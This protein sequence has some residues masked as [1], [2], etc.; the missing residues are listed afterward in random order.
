MC[1]LRSHPRTGTECPSMTD[2][3]NT[4][5][6][7]YSPFRHLGEGGP[8]HINQSIEDFQEPTTAQA[9]GTNKRDKRELIPADFVEGVDASGPPVQRSG[10]EAVSLTRWDLGLP[11]LESKR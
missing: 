9:R 1:R 6:E 5:S 7:K 2:V 10:A 11:E 3:G 8:R 4:A